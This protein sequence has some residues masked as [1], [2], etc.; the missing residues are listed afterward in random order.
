ML[1]RAGW[2]VCV[3]MFSVYARYFGTVC[4][5]EGQGPFV[6]PERSQLRAATAV[7][8]TPAP[9]ASKR[10]RGRAW[11]LHLSQPR[12][13]PVDPGLAPVR[14]SRAGHGQ[15]EGERKRHLVCF[16]ALPQPIKKPLTNCRRFLSSICVAGL[17]LIHKAL[18][19]QESSPTTRF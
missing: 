5:I 15:Q 16:R 7:H 6:S 12:I 3:C 1:T 14:V 11:G 4:R 13:L 8:P 17:C 10:G 19:P 9:S 18:F 2:V